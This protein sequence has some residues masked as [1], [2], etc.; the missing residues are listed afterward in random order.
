LISYIDEHGPLQKDEVKITSNG[1]HQRVIHHEGVL[2]K[3]MVR[4][5]YL[6]KRGRWNI[7]HVFFLFFFFLFRFKARTNKTKQ[8]RRREE[9]QETIALLQ[10]QTVITT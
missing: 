8:N 5:S 2:V 6:S 10:N 9:H 3:V 7:V 4:T 1:S